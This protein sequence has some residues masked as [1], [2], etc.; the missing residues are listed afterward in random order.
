VFVSFVEY[1]MQDAFG[2]ELAARVGFPDLE[3]GLLLWAI[4]G[5]EIRDDDEFLEGVVEMLLKVVE[6]RIFGLFYFLL[7][8]A[9]G[10]LSR[11]LYNFRRWEAL[12]PFLEIFLSIGLDGTFK[13]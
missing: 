1:E 11:F 13:N 6:G 2:L 7:L 5:V 10:F 9:G 8:L 12:I 4:F 3:C